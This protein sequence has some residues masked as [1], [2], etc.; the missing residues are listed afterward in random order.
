MRGILLLMQTGYL[1]RRSLGLKPKK[2][3]TPY[4][5]F[6]VC[7]QAQPHLTCHKNVELLL[8]FT[9]RFIQKHNI[10]IPGH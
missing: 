2:K 6:K 7:K 4:P 10:P 3:E 8:V 9:I 1:S 5:L